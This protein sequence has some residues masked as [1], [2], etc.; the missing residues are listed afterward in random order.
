[1]EDLLQYRFKDGRLKNQSFGNLFLAAMDGISN[2][3][4][5]AIKR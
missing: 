1:M 4:E 3:F 2:N 5:E